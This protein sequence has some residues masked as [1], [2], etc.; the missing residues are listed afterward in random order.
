[1]QAGNIS[2]LEKI[3]KSCRN[4]GYMTEMKN[5]GLYV[6]L[7]PITNEDRLKLKKEITAHK[8]EVKNRINFDR[9]EVRKVFLKKNSGFSE[10]EQRKMSKQVD[11]EKDKLYKEL[12]TLLTKKEK[13]IMG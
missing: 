11:T 1:M 4:A 12:D 7:Q 6:S 8:E 9:D 5:S 13:E 10:D 2:L 3:E